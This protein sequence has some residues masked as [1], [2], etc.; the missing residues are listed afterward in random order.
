[1][2]RG[3]PGPGS[4]L[5]RPGSTLVWTPPRGARSWR[6]HRGMAASPAPGAN[7][8]AGRPG[9]HVGGTRA[10]LHACWAPESP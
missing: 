4:H 7:S 2:S 9:V 6:G 3:A 1:L 10:G 8:L 5:K